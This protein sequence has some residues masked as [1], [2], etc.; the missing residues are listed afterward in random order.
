[1]PLITAIDGMLLTDRVFP[2]A[3]LSLVN[4]TSKKDLALSP[5]SRVHFKLSRRG[6]TPQ[7]AGRLTSLS[8]LSRT[9]INT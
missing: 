7:V 4:S 9:A 8:Y 6:V 1:M 2:L 5:F 3:H